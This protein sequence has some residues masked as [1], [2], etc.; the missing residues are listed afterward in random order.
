MN[1]DSNFAKNV[2]RDSDRSPVIALLLAQYRSIQTERLVLVTSMRILWFLLLLVFAL[3]KDPTTTLFISLGII[4][5]SLFFISFHSSRRTRSLEINIR[6][7]LV[8]LDP[9]LQDFYIKV[10]HE[11]REARYRTPIYTMAIILRRFED[12]VWLCSCFYI[13]LIRL[14]INI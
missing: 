3:A 9:D 12:L 14:L 6:D 11:A 1:T 13:A 7:S 5:I 4:A 10:L 2:K 8:R